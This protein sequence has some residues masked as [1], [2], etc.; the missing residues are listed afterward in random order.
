MTSISTQDVIKA[1]KACLLA[2][3][4]ELLRRC[5]FLVV[6]ILLIDILG[7]VV[8]LENSIDDLTLE[9]MEITW[10][11]NTLDMTAQYV[12]LVLSFMVAVRTHH[13][14]A[15]YLEG[16]TIHYSPRLYLKYMRYVI[17]LALV[18]GLVF[19]SAFFTHQYLMYAAF[20]IF[21]YLGCRLSLV[22]PSA[23]LGDDVSLKRSWLLT[24]TC[25]Y[26]LSVVLVLIPLALYAPLILMT[27]ID[28]ESVALWL[29]SDI[30]ASIVVFI[31]VSVFTV[32]YCKILE[33]DEYAVKF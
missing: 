14:V 4:P 10:W 15:V 1:S 3:W 13:V 32:L 19:L 16:R 27:Y 21:A 23:A 24:R 7:Y 25:Q 12:S 5:G 6:I 11:L 29:L 28:I 31:E 20:A 8:Y 26:P 30:A 22:F 17:A 2:C 33:S 9:G 18:I